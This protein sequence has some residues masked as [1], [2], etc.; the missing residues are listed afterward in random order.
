MGFFYASAWRIDGMVV[1]RFSVYCIAMKNIETLLSA[2]WIIPVNPSSACLED[3]SIAVNA[4]RIE[5]I[6]PTA[7]ALQEYH[8]DNHLQLAEH[9]LIPGLINTHT[10]AAMSLLRGLADDITLHAWLEKHIWPAETRWVDRQFISDGSQLAI[11]EMIRSGTTCFNDM[12]FYPDE[13]GRIASLAGIRA[14]VGL[15]VIEFPTV[16]AADTKEY[17]AKGIEVHDRLNND[18]LVTTAFAPH[19]PYTVSDDSLDKIAVLADE[20]DIPIHMHVHETAEEVEKAVAQNGMRPLARLDRHGMISP[21]LQAV[22]MNHLNADE[23][24]TVAE[25]GCQVVHCPESNLKL[26]SGLC[27]VNALRASGINTALGTDGAAS[28]NDLDMFGEMRTAAL[29]A[30]GLSGDTESMTATQV[31]AMATING[32]R[33]LGL[34]NDTGSLETGKSADITAVR[35]DSIETTPV[36]DPVSH[37]VYCANRDCVTDVW[38]AG[39]HLLKDRELTTLDTGEILEKARAW[40]RKIAS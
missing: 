17:F 29:L 27:P 4:G 26:A 8:A 1:R 33:A 30:K 16:W 6:L 5:A 7:A 3:H 40:G 38:V 35:L 36:Y 37:L 10:H 32:A 25:A 23:I 12:Y 2:R 20:L 14:C 24:Q 13:T 28:N 11:A 19:A 31:L 15:I 39:R 18:P 34:E 22:H 9:A 21:R